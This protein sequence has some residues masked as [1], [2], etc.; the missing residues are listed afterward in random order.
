LRTLT[1]EYLT[2]DRCRLEYCRIGQATGEAPTIVFLHEG[3]GSIT[4]WKDFPAA[5]CERVG[6]RGLVYN[7]RGYGGSDPLDRLSPEFMHHEALDV[8]PGMLDAL[9]IERPVLFGHSDGGSIALIYAGSGRPAPAAMILEAAHVFVE[10]VT[11]R[12][13]AELSAAYRSSDLRAR[14]ERHHGSNV[15]RLFD[16]WTRTWLSPEFRG[17]NIEQYLHRIDCPALV[18][19]GRDDEYG[20]LRQVNAIAAAVTGAETLV[21]DGCGHAPHIERRDEVLE[22]A[23]MFVQR[24]QVVTHDPH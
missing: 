13:I 8:L 6:C 18:M 22:A 20:T 16:E 1:R 15:D 11:V 14:L 19:Q 23:A 10:D 3:L 5:L 2:V 24:L 7:R 12:R 21:I 9:E 17:W 4:Q